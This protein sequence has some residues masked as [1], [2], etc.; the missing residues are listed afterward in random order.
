MQRRSRGRRP[1]CEWERAVASVA[2]VRGNAAADTYLFA[3]GELQCTAARASSTAAAPR[4]LEDQTF[5]TAPAPASTSGPK[6][7]RR[8][9]KEERGRKTRHGSARPAG[10]VTA[11][12]EK[13]SAAE[14]AAST[15]PRELSDPAAERPGGSAASTPGCPGATCSQSA[16]STRSATSTD[17]PYQARG[18][19]RPT[20]AACIT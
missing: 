6:D 1:D 5:P 10:S 13:D 4:R 12:A 14:A 9:G 2:S 20:C 19:A 3:S 15:C 11:G 7:E 8:S 17:G 16:G 18:A